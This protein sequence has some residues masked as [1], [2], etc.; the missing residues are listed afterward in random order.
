M[1]LFVCGCLPLNFDSSRDLSEDR[2]PRIL[3]SIEE[4]LRTAKCGSF[5]KPRQV[6]IRRSTAPS[7]DDL[8][9]CGQEDN[10]RDTKSQHVD[11]SC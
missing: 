1:K 4:E 3:E 6:Y 10:M 2:G 9:D 5:F 7:P 11:S 8:S